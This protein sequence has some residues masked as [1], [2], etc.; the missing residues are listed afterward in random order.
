MIIP[1]ENLFFLLCYAWN[2]LLPAGMIDVRKL[3]GNRVNDLLAAVLVT[4][5]QR[6]V[7]QGLERQYIASTIEIPGVRGKLQMSA[8]I[9]RLAHVRG[10]AVCSFAELNPDT[11][12]N[13]IIRSTVRSLLRDP[14]LDSGLRHPLA[15][16]FRGLGDVHDENLTRASFRSVQYHRNNR[17]YRFLIRICRLWLSRSFV[18]EETGQTRFRDFDR[19]EEG[20]RVLFEKFVRNFYRHELRHAQVSAITTHWDA[21]A[22]D[23]DSLDILPVLR[24]DTC[25]RAADRLLVIDTKF[26]ESFREYRASKKAKEAHLFQLFAYLMNLSRDDRFAGLRLS[27]MLLYPMTE[28]AEDFPLELFGFPFAIR[29]VN[30]AAPWQQIAARLHEIYRLQNP[31][32]AATA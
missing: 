2:A 21:A 8:T 5:L 27:G 32:P 25:I 29:H 23:P 14:E 17:L 10:R 31:A 11:P 12:A 18:D 20:L 30:L 4:G 19:S 9:K 7:R 24:T 6:L 26:T 15:R 16:F 3:P 1:I 28:E 13:R 22:T